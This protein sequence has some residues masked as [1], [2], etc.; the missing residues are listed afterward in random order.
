MDFV[1]SLP[2][3]PKPFPR[4]HLRHVLS[5]H[6]DIRQGSAIDIMAVRDDADLPLVQKLLEPQGRFKAARLRSFRSVVATDANAAGTIAKRVS[7]DRAN[8]LPFDPVPRP[9]LLQ[10]IVGEQ[11]E[12][13]AS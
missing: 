2:S 8:Q 11:A 10:V 7:I 5:I 9:V 6:E 12:V 4:H 1:R 3:P 13:A